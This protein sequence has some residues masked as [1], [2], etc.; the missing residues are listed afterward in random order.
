[1]SDCAYGE[2]YRVYARLFPRRLKITSRR[3]GVAP[4]STHPGVTKLTERVQE[5]CRRL[6]P[7]LGRQIDLVWSTY[8]AARDAK[9]RADI[10]QT[11]QLLAAKHLGQSYEP[12]RAPFPPPPDGILTDGDVHIGD[13][14][15]ADRALRP[16]TLDSTRLAEHAIICGRSGS[17]KTTLTFNLLESALDRGIKVLALDWKRG[18]RDMLKRRPDLLVYTVGRDVAPLRFNPLIPPPGCEPQVWIKLVVDVMANA[19]L[20]GEGVISLLVAG[21]D[22]LFR[23]NG[24]FDPNPKRWPT[25]E[26]LLDWLRSEKLYGRAAMWKASAERILLG[27]TYGEFGA[28]LNTASNTH[29]QELLEH[30]VVL[31]MDGLS[32][33]SDRVMFSE[34]L[35]LYIYRYRLAQGPR[36]R[37]TNLIVLEEAHNLLLAKAPGTKESVLESS[38]RMIRQYGI[39]YLFVDQSAS[40]LS[41]VAFANSY[42]T[43]A[44]SQ[45]LRADVQT[46][47]GAMNL[48]DGQKDALNTL[49]IGT[50]VVRVADGHP[51]PFLVRVPRSPVQEGAVSDD[52]V[53]I[54]MNRH[55]GY[56]GLVRAAIAATATISRIPVQDKKDRDSIDLGNPHPPS[57]RS[58]GPDPPYDVES[59][60]RPPPE[61]PLSREA[62]RFLDDVARRPL[63]TTV[64]RYQRLHLSRRRGNAIRRDLLAADAITGTAI[65][66]RSGQVMLYELTDSG[67]SLCHQIGLEAPAS[68]R[69]SLEHR[70]WVS[71]VV[72][73][74]DRR[75]YE[76][77]AET[78]VGDKKH[79]DVT[80]VRPGERIAIEVETG[81]SNIKANL[82]KLRSAGFN[83][84]I[85][86]ATSPAAVAPC[87]QAVDV[88]LAKLGLQA[89]LWTWLDLP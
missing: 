76:T 61:E 50:A 66:T 20:G 30:D 39:G 16:F 54:R 79:V 29:L 48:S 64:A 14:L 25:I 69:P 11:L 75:G 62:I 80:A 38:I 41:K 15:Y 10:E 19:Y 71:K 37:L 47:A 81:K 6:R 4:S 46:M 2:T 21:L 5:L 83:K 57:P 13:V 23:K 18:Y 24:A 51:E 65:A 31:E 17:G 85:V 49:P 34:A 89:E 55:S 26:E 35:T 84:V 32:S 60:V 53:R 40:L 77:E 27:M 68:P 86:I 8:M 67:R 42:A 78:L 82:E 59:A 63:S 3:F 74:F 88:G 7:V 52:D 58:S 72:E 45:K 44:L 28:V 43:F 1:M 70:Y 22:Q 73:H 87:Q 56:S 33:A 12:D 36:K 9:E